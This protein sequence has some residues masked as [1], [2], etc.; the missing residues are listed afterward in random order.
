MT[1]SSWIPCWF[2]DQA[3]VS[4]SDG[5]S[6]HEV[7]LPWLAQ[8]DV[9]RGAPIRDIAL[10]P[11]G[12]MWILPASSS[13]APGGRRVSA[14]LSRV[15]PSGAER[16]SVPLAPAARLI[17]RADASGCV[18]LTVNGTLLRVSDRGGS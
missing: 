4:I 2:V 12:S 15:A 3:I 10:M 8:S 11:D 5:T 6:A 1:S 16:E 13:T 7:R 18:L 9:N 14:R 17:V